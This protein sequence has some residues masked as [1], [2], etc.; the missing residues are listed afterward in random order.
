[1]KISGALAVLKALEHEG[2]EVIFG[3]PGGASMPMYDPLVDASPIRHEGCCDAADRWPSTKRVEP[4]LRRDGRVLPG[5]AERLPRCVRG[6]RRPCGRVCSLAE[7]VD[8]PVQVR[9]EDVAVAGGHVLLRQG[10]LRER[11]TSRRNAP[12]AL[13]RH[14]LVGR[15]ARGDDHGN[16][17]RECLERR[18]AEAF[19]AVRLN[20]HVRGAV[21]RW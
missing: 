6:T 5:E 19:G 10:A 8:E 15:P 2:V 16:A 3:I 18:Q 21:Q 13:V 17:A 9:L 14:E 11:L 4:G 1:M 12:R 20:E 7:C